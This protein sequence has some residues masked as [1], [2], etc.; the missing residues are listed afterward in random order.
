MKF[1]KK[2]KDEAYERSGGRCECTREDGLHPG[3]RCPERLKRKGKKTNFNH[4]HADRL[5][6][7]DEPSNCEVICRRCHERTDSYGRN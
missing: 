1:T 3:R 4:L 6:G 7:A 5:S 2:T